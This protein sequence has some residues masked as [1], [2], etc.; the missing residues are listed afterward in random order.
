MRS[1]RHL[2]FALWLALALVVGQQ[3]AALHSLA[4]ANES[5]SHKKGT[6]PAQSQCETCS[7]LAGFA[8]AMGAH[9]AATPVVDASPP[10]A[11]LPRERIAELSNRV[12]YL[13]RAPPAL[14]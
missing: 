14:S 5:L 2:G 10:R 4:H 1:L 13:S 9:S 6:S 3:G 7:Q 8:G 11:L 12:A